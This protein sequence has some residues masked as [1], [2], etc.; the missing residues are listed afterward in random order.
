M[1]EYIKLILAN[2]GVWTAFLNLVN[3]VIFLAVP[4]FPK[5]LW[6]A[7]SALVNMVLAAVGIAVT[8]V[9]KARAQFGSVRN[10]LGAI[11]ARLRRQS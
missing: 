10:A 11:V 6:V 7:I 1:K 8:V 5:E 2:G 4:N 9:R 3:V